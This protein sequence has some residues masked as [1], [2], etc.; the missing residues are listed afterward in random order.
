[1]LAE[2]LRDFL[3]QIYLSIVVVICYHLFI[4]SCQM[5]VELLYLRF[6]ILSIINYLAHPAER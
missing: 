3:T 2:I 5:V 1:M 6:S 4:F